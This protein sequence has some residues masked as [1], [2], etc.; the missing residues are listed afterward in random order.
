MVT[1]PGG[2]T[3]SLSTRF[4]GMRVGV[5]GKPQAIFYLPLLGFKGI[6]KVIKNPPASLGKGV[7]KSF[8]TITG[9]MQL[10]LG[11]LGRCPS[12]GRRGI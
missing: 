7:K 1:K 3:Y 12:P 10:S 6:S 11:K 4:G 2:I 8:Q 9:F 5:R